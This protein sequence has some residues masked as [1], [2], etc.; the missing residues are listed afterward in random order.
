MDI[1]QT[2]NLEIEINSNY[3][4]LKYNNFNNQNKHYYSYS[5]GIYIGYH[6]RMREIRQLYCQCF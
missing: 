3:D 5:Q 6:Q 4:L 1:N 2:F